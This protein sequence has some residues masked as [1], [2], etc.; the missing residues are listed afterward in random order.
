MQDAI[1]WAAAYWDDLLVAALAGWLA[2]RVV[3][4]RGPDPVASLVAGLL[5]WLV[6]SGLMAVL[7]IGITGAPAILASF[8][9]ALAG[10]LVLWLSA[11]LLK[12]A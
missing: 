7:G 4:G 6:G 5:G 3:R 11:G 9:A 10:A 8:L 2:G 1:G 12:R